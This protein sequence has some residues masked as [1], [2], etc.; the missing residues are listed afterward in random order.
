MTTITGSNTPYLHFSVN[1]KCESSE[2]QSTSTGNF[3]PDN[4][5]LNVI[6]P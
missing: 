6:D 2:Q 1:H 5:G 3:V 4:T